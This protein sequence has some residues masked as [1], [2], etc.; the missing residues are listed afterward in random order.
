MTGA[1]HLQA[2]AG[3]A[4]AID[5]FSQVVASCCRVHSEI[6]AAYIFGS[7]ACRPDKRPKDLDIA[8]LI[9]HDRQLDFPL[10]EFISQ[11]EKRID[12]PVDVVVLNR[13]GEVL[14]YEVRRTG[15]LVFER[16][17]DDRKRFEIL[18][19]KTYE[20][21]LHMHRR[22]ADKVLYGENKLSM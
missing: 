22:Y 12:L 19:R 9:A 11:M 2:D 18:G 6:I 8:L 16:D 1:S 10:F 15:K 7:V 4:G 14:K 17:G 21:F 20:D 13:A 5:I 3:P